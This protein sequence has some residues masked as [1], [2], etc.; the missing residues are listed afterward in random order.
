MTENESIP[1][2]FIGLGSMGEPMALNLAKA[3]THLLVW[4]RIRA[5]TLPLGAA[6]A[7]VASDSGNLFARAR[8]NLHAGRQ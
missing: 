3:G 4:N 5:K 6:G 7:K 8:T 2:G 1:I